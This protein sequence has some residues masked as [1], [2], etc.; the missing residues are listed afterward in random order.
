M[1]IL[2]KYILST[3]RWLRHYAKKGKVEKMEQLLAKLHG[4][5]RTQVLTSKNWKGQTALHLAARKSQLPAVQLLLDALQK[6]SMETVVLEKDRDGN[7]PLHH[8]ILGASRAFGSKHLK[9]AQ[10]LLE[11]THINDNHKELLHSLL[12]CMAQQPTCY[13]TILLHRQETGGIPFES[14]LDKTN[15]SKAGNTGKGNTQVQTLL[16]SLL[17]HGAV[18]DE[19]VYRAAERTRAFDSVRPNMN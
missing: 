6:V 11:H 16:T 9:I 8:C 1:R 18:L 2:L 15:W 10:L 13:E 5:K 4:T 3:D 19:T 7:T 17:E 14:A 12:L